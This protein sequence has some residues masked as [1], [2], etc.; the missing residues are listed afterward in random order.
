MSYGGQY[1]LVVISLTKRALAG[2]MP[3]N[4]RLEFLQ[5]LEK[6]T[7]QWLTPEVI[8]MVE[9]I[10][11]RGYDLSREAAKLGYKARPS[12]FDIYAQKFDVFAALNPSLRRAY[13]TAFKRFNQPLD[14]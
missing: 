3:I 11:N 14:V 2:E 13:D 8:A 5:H 10:D 6:L 12:A 9:P 1:T 4:M 7:D